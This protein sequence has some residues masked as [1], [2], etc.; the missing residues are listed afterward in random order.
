MKWVAGDG[1]CFSWGLII[2]LETVGY[3]FVF[4]YL[5]ADVELVLCS[6]KYNHEINWNSVGT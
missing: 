3:Y 5:I 6:A 2:L 4:R 1:K